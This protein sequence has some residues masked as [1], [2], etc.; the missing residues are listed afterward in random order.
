MT[1]TLDAVLHA[2]AARRGRL[3]VLT[4]AGISAAS[5]IPTFRG[6]GGFWTIGSQAYQPEEIAT[7]AFFGRQPQAVW[8]WY[9]YRAGVCGAA[10][11]NAAHR[12]LVE[13][14]HRLGDRFVLVTQNVDGLHR[15]AGSS[16]E[17]T[18][19]VHGTLRAVR[20]SGACAGRWPL[21]AGLVPRPG[22][23]PLRPEEEAAL[24]CPRCGAWLRP[25]VL[26][27]DECYDE[28][29][30]RFESA[31]AAALEAALLL[32]IGTSGAT[33]LPM[34]MAQLASARGVPLVDIDP[35]PNPF[36]AL[37]ASHDGGVFVQEPAVRA[38]PRVVERLLAIWAPSR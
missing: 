7:R 2:A 1:P 18:W 28:E 12:A 3:V 33:A 20:C 22:G 31:L 11:P 13:L 30:Y 10:A 26:W 9:L 15:R 6:P 4:G 38:V 32:V 19:E 5:G 16:P 23:E 34:H 37:A 25:H 8:G 21:P 35:D 29:N 27:F 17:R 36:G 14:E 24:R